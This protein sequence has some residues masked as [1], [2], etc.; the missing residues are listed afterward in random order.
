MAQFVYAWRSVFSQQNEEAARNSSKE[1]LELTDETEENSTECDCPAVHA[2]SRRPLRSSIVISHLYAMAACLHGDDIGCRGNAPP[3]A[4]AAW[5]SDTDRNDRACSL[6]H[7]EVQI[8]DRQKC[9]SRPA[10]FLS[11]RSVFI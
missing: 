11:M 5:H 8:C 10:S 3:V 4:M 1:N 2:A 6:L 7:F 9:F